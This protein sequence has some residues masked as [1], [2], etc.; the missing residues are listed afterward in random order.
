MTG[1]G[2][3]EGN[4]NSSSSVTKPCPSRSR[5]AKLGQTGSLGGR[6][7]DTKAVCDVSPRGARE[8]PGGGKGTEGG[9][10]EEQGIEKYGKKNISRWGGG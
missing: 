3:G 4:W 1:S 8:R 2:C 5:H 6:E 10:T 9:E 7:S